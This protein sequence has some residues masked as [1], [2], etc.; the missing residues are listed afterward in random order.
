VPG[1][2][3]FVTTAA[4]A[5]L[6]GVTFASKAV[7]AGPDA[8]RDICGRFRGQDQGLNLMEVEKRRAFERGV[9]LRTRSDFEGDSRKT[10]LGG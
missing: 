3:L 1:P 2:E 4:G 6:L 10:S 9:L 8:A 7:V 5:G